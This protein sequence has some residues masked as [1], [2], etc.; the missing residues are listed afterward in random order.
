M[1]PPADGNSTTVQQPLMDVT[2]T[3][4]YREKIIA[5]VNPKSYVIF[6]L[7]KNISIKKSVLVVVC[8]AKLFS[9]NYELK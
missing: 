9:N 5:F 7:I 8:K 2:E 6:I 3:D 4:A 1:D